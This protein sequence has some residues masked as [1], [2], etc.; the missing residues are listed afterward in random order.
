LPTGGWSDMTN[1]IWRERPPILS[2]TS[3]RRDHRVLA[4]I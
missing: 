1:S 2:S 3:R 4:V